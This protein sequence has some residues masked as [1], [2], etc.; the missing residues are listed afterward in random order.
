MALC[1]GANPLRLFGLIFITPLNDDGRE[2]CRTLRA[3]DRV[4]AHGV[5][6]VTIKDLRD[7]KSGAR[8]WKL[9]CPIA[10]LAWQRLRGGGRGV[11]GAR[12][13]CEIANDGS[14]AGWRRGL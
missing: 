11:V 10:S 7:M 6:Q 3:L 5:V 12:L 2:G 8:L 14:K 1:H 13:D 9:G 4:R